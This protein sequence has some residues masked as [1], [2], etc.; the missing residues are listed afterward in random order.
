[1]FW[2]SAFFLSQGLS[3]NDSYW[4][5]PQNFTGK[6]AEYNLY[7][8]K[9]S[10]ILS[11]VAYTGHRQE[12][13]LFSTSP[14]FTTSGMLPKAWRLIQKRGIYLYKGGTSGY[15]NAGKELYSEFYSNQIA[16]TI[17]LN[18]VQ[19][20]FEKWKEILASTCKLFT[21]INISYVPIGRIVKTGGLEA[22][23]DYYK[24]KGQTL[25]IN[26]EIG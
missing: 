24:I 17:G 20:N 2:L 16:K 6:F 23:A 5:V 12:D 13:A 3:L 10:E 7:E 15:V 25:T 18:A 4:V 19:Y 11:L 22:V 21:N 9:F 14:E 26:F 8:N 1:M